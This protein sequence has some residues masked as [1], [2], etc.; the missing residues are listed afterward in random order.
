M[1]IPYKFGCNIDIMI[2]AKMK[3]QAIFKLYNKYPILDC[4]IEKKP[5]SLGM[6]WASNRYVDCDCC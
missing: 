3:E 2:E 4:R 1:E 5:I 6:Q